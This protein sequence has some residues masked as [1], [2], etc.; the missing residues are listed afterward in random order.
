MTVLAPLPSAVA[1]V[2]E[3][4]STSTITTSRPLVSEGL[5]C[6]GVKKTSSRTCRLLHQFTLTLEELGV[7]RT[8][9]KFLVCHQAAANW[10]RS[11]NA[12]HYKDLTPHVHAD[13]G[14]TSERSRV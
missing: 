14:C 13:Q 5:A 10:H 1:T 2:V 11:S 7:H 8:F 3:A 9:L 12:F 6:A 4:R